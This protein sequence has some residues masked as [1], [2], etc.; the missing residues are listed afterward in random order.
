MTNCEVLH[1]GFT[2]AVFVAGGAAGYKFIKD[3]EAQEEDTRWKKSERA[4]A[5]KKY[6]KE[7]GLTRPPRRPWMMPERRGG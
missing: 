7:I 1:G 5:E 6:A 4:R 3:A 2:W